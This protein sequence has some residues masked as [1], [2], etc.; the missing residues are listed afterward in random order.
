[1]KPTGELRRRGQLQAGSSLLIYLF[2][3]SCFFFFFFFFFAIKP[4]ASFLINFLSETTT[5]T[6]SKTLCIWLISGWLD[7]QSAWRRYYRCK[8]MDYFFLLFFLPGESQVNLVCVQVAENETT[9]DIRS[10]C[11]LSENESYVLYFFFLFFRIMRVTVTSSHSGHDAASKG[12]Y[13]Y[14]PVSS[15]ARAKW[16][17]VYEGTC[18]TAIRYPCSSEESTATQVRWGLLLVQKASR[19]LY[20]LFA[21]RWHGPSR[22]GRILPRASRRSHHYFPSLW[23]IL[24]NARELKMYGTYILNQKFDSIRIS[25]LYDKIKIWRSNR[26]CLRKRSKNKYCYIKNATDS[27]WFHNYCTKLRSNEC[28]IYYDSWWRKK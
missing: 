11:L 22:T 24:H 28:M 20:L 6:K 25:V 18:A 23:E 1:M 14:C 26:Q 21:H 12:L 8:F 3:S 10:S 15:F 27:A 16:N 5:A 17:V 13:A 19:S 4:N 9:R 7:F 2:A